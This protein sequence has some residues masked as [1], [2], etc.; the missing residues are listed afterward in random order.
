MYIFSVGLLAMRYATPWIA[1][2]LHF[3]CLAGL[4]SVFD[5]GFSNWSML[6]ITIELYTMSKST[7]VIFILVFG[8]IFHLQ[9]PVSYSIYIFSL[10]WLLPSN[11]VRPP[12][13]HVH[14]DK[15]GGILALELASSDT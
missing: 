3:S 4:A 5:I 15:G 9:E 1:H 2:M 6:Y 7:A 11:L 13:L 14:V 8:I 12:V 10:S